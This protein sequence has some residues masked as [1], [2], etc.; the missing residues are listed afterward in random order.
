MILLTGLRQA[1]T[2]VTPSLSLQNSVSGS[3]TIIADVSQCHRVSS[4]LEAG[5]V[6][7]TLRLHFVDAYLSYSGLGQSIQCSL[8]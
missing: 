5:T 6:G 2:P 8:Q 4:A 1:F 3:Q 7:H